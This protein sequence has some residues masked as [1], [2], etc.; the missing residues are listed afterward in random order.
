MVSSKCLA[1]LYWLT[2]LPTRSPIAAAPTSLPVRSG[3]AGACRLTPSSQSAP[4]DHRET[5]RRL[6]VTLEVPFRYR[7]V[8]PWAGKRRRQ[9]C[10]FCCAENDQV[11][12]I[13]VADRWIVVDVES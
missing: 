8:W 2:T 9:F 5:P 12:E 7:Q 3:Q 4:A 6:P 1:T 13:K 10:I 11:I